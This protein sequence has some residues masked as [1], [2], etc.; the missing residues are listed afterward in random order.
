[1]PRKKNII[2]VDQPMAPE[3]ALGQEPIK[4]TEPVVQ[5]EAI[6]AATQVEPAAAPEELIK[7]ILAEPV[8]VDLHI[9]EPVKVIPAIEPEIEKPAKKPVVKLASAA[10]VKTI[11]KTDNIIVAGQKAVKKVDVKPIEKPEKKPLTPDIM[12]NVTL[13]GTILFI[14]VIL[15]CLI[16]FLVNFKGEIKNQGALT[17]Q[18]VTLLLSKVSKHIKLP[19]D[20]KPTIATI[21]DVQILQSQQPF[22]KD[23]KN[24]DR[25]ILYSNKA[26]I[27]SEKENILV[28]VGPIYMEAPPATAT[29][30]ATNSPPTTTAAEAQSQPT[31]PVKV[32]IRNGG[33]PKGS[34]AAWA[35]KIK[36]LGGFEIAGTKNATKRY[37]EGVMVNLKG[38]DVARLKEIFKKEPVN[39]LPEGEEA[40]TADV[41]ILLGAN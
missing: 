25:L 6:E 16:Q 5:A 13:F 21:Q 38:K 24:G 39:Q 14:V 34:A 41:L 2:N 11:S 33:A 40:S 23:A 18:E 19:Q 27:Y 1:M 26:I 8:S 28:N 15:A 30:T 10:R 3:A 9:D 36:A 7:P 29:S 22:F 4:E 17:E 20:E 12:R 35:E 37:A 31:E 32:E